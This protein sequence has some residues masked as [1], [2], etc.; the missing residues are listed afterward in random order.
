MRTLT[1]F[2]L[3]MPDDVPFYENED[4]LVRVRHSTLYDYR[5]TPDLQDHFM[6]CSDHL[7]RN[8]FVSLLP[9]MDEGDDEKVLDIGLRYY[10]GCS[11]RQVNIHR[12]IYVWEMITDVEHDTPVPSSR[13]SPS[14]LARAYSCLTHAYFELHRAAYNGEAVERDPTLPLDHPLPTRTPNPTLANDLLYVAALYADAAV[15]EGLVSPITLYTA[16]WILDVGKRDGI[17]LKR[18]A[19]YG[20]LT[21]LWRAEEARTRE[22]QAEQKKKA[23]KVAKAPNAY[24][25][26]AP[27]CGIAGNEKKALMKCGGRCPMARK[28]HYCSKEC[29]KKDWKAHKAYCKPD[30]ELS[31][32]PPGPPVDGAPKLNAEDNTIPLPP[33]L[34]DANYQGPA[35]AIEMDIPGEGRV[36]LESRNLTPAVLR[37]MRDMVTA[38]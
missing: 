5:H 31:E 6:Q 35:H 12:A 2:T 17:D 32:R 1:Q 18:S 13:V 11:V 25:C 15:Q 9:G 7:S 22:Y 34:P 10:S 14:L 30:D 37:W 38:Q 4:V 29:Q 27:G 16:S 20:G 36:R 8:P 24:I 19:R 33:P 3:E 28:P 23:A 21:Y 26:A